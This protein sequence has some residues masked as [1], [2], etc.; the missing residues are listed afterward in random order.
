MFALIA[1][2]RARILPCSVSLGLE[3]FVCGRLE[4]RFRPGSSGPSAPML[5]ATGPGAGVGRR[6]PATSGGPGTD[7]VPVCLHRWIVTRHRMMTGSLSTLTR[8]TGRLA[9]R[10]RVLAGVGAAGLS[11]AD[12]EHEFVFAGIDMERQVDVGGTTESEWSGGESPSGGGA[13]EEDEGAGP[14]YSANASGGIPPERSI[15]SRSASS[16]GP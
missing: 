2:V 12:G 3:W 16:S 10:V 11:G 9:V 7:W 1:T 15:N 13:A 6:P 5:V 8:T 4:G 14:P